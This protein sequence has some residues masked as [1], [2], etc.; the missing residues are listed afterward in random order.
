MVGAG[1]HGSLSGNSTLSPA[2]RPLAWLRG[3][4]GR[5]RPQGGWLEETAAWPQDTGGC[6]DFVEIALQALPWEVKKRK[7]V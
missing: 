2:K 5:S 7:R 1:R 6:L 4:P 3:R